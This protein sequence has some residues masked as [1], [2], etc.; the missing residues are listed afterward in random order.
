MRECFP[1]SPFS[2]GCLGLA[3]VIPEIQVLDLVACMIERD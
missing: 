3:A 1:S 2:G